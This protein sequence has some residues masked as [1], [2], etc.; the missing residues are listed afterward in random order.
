MGQSNDKGEDMVD[1]NVLE[2]STLFPDSLV[3]LEGTR[4][5][6]GNHLHRYIDQTTV[7]PVESVDP[8][9]DSIVH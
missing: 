6:A 3:Y 7:E 4:I 8:S 9:V 5:F 1:C 2:C